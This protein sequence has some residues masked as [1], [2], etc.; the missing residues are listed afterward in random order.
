MTEEDFKFDEGREIVIGLSGDLHAVQFGENL[1]LMEVL[2]MLE[3]AKDT[4]ICAFMD[5]GDE[6]QGR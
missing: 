4:A 6:E 5:E 1:G 2:G 3:L